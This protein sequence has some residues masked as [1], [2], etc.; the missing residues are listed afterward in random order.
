MATEHK[1]NVQIVQDR[2]LERRQE[3]VENRPSLQQVLVS[4]FTQLIWFIVAVI[5]ILMGCRFVLMLVAANPENGFARLVYSIT[6]TL[7]SPFI[8]LVDS[9]TFDSGA[10]LDIPSLF[11]LA[12]YPLVG[13]GIVQL[14]HILFASRGGI[15]RTRSVRRTKIHD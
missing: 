14:V 1:E 7:V 10:V 4:R 11:A 5:A 9:P 15:R 13:W 6:G 8:G 2:G 3:V 12:V